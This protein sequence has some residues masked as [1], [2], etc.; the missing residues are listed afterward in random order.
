MLKPACCHIAVRFFLIVGTLIGCLPIASALAQSLE[1]SWLIVQSTPIADLPPPYLPLATGSNA[2]A[3]GPYAVS[4]GDNSTSYSFS[5]VASGADSSAV[6]LNQRGK[7]HPQPGGRR[8][9]PCSRH[10]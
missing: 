9:E 1:T 10:L 6:R 2:L 3:A 5:A 7:R 8:S 4:S